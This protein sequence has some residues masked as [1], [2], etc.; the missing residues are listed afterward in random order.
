MTFRDWILPPSSGISPEDWQTNRY[1]R[2]WGVQAPPPAPWQP[3]GSMQSAGTGTGARNPTQ[4]RAIILVIAVVL[5][6]VGLS[7]ITGRGR[8]A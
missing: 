6:F 7:Y 2:N 3:G 4:E 1:T 5:A 8:G